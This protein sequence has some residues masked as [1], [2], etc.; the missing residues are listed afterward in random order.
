MN[1]FN[2]YNSQATAE[3]KFVKDLDRLEM[4]IQAAEYEDGLIQILKSLLYISHMV[5]TFQ[6]DHHLY[7]ITEQ[8]IQLQE[9]F[10]ST[11]GLIQHPEVK[12]WENALRTMQK[13]K[14]KS[15]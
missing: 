14:N 15:N 4:I 7:K 10:T 11:N 6:C 12:T 5:L 8:N 9:F 3:A 2:E 13:D 1:L